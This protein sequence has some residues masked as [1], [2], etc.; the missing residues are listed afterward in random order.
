[1][2]QRSAA[3]AEG[4]GGDQLTAEAKAKWRDPEVQKN[5]RWL[6][7]VRAATSDRSRNGVLTR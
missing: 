3:E 7:E 2:P 1:M 4:G 5:V 6:A